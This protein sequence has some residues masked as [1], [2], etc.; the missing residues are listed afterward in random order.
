MAETSSTV[1]VNEASVPLLRPR[2]ATNTDLTS[3]PTTLALLL[4][5]AAGRRGPSMLVRETAALQLEE[6]RADWGFSKPVVALDIAWN[7]AFTVGAIVMLALTTNEKPNTPIR[8]WIC[9][10]ALQCVVHVVL[11]WLEY[12]RRNMRR[13][14][15]GEEGVR[16]S[17]SELN[18]SD[19]ED[20]DGG[21]TSGSR[22][23]I[24]KRCE[25][26]NTMASFLWWIVGFYWVVSGG[27][28]LLQDA[29]RLYWLAVIFLAFD[30]FFAIFCV[31][32]ACLIGVA[33]CCC[34][35]CIIG[36]LYA[37]AGQEGASEADLT[38][39]PKYKFRIRSDEKP[40]AGAGSMVPIETNSGCL[41]DE[42][43]L[44]PEH[45][46]CCVCLTPYED[47]VELHALPCNHHFHASCIVKWLKINATCPLC[48]Y[49]IVKGNNELV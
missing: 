8:V 44:L 25:S 46:E 30:V 19:D 1:T 18:D 34:L 32:L 23:R 47:G 38:I 39:L 26:V 2:Q 16:T 35:P 10:Y 22:S 9:G 29:P 43:L 24:A 33:L 5:R 45:A 15:G 36:I 14:R 7:L 28:S 31:A 4:G 11:V 42:R 49:N 37:V 12:R 17:D 3:R 13:T 48:K 40:N 27:N 20:V 41:A 21:R 6:R